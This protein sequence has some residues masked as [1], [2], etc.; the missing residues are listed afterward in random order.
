MVSLNMLREMKEKKRAWFL[1]GGVWGPGVQP[2]KAD[3]L[4]SGAEAE[5]GSRGGAGR[6]QK[7]LWSPR[8]RLLELLSAESLEDFVLTSHFMGEE[9][10]NHQM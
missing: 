3:Q 1:L 10:E 6:A 2:P 4:R 5:G 8:Q 7:H 9:T